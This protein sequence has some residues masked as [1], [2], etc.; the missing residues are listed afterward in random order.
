VKELREKLLDAVGVRVSVHGFHRD[1]KEQRFVREVSSGCQ[2]LHLAFINHHDDF[3]VTADVAVRIEEVERIVNATNAK[4][5]AKEKRLTSTAG[6]EL[7]NLEGRGQLRWTV[8]RE[9]DIDSVSSAI[10]REF[11]RVGLPFFV[12]LQ[13]PEALL[14]VLRDNER[15]G[16]LHAPVHAA[17]CMRAVALASVLREPDVSRLIQAEEAFLAERR[18]FGLAAFREFAAAFKAS[19]R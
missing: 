15:E 13:Q 18:D 9:T 12:R 7:G 6:G 10:A 14:S 2:S 3:D 4:L 16:W 5:S 8:A 11:R 19:T 17:R 1:R